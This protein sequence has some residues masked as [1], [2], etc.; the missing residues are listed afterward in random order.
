MQGVIKFVLA[1][2]L[3]GT[4]ATL[5]ALPVTAHIAA[6]RH[7][8]LYYGAA[9]GSG[10]TLVGNTGNGNG[11]IT[12]TWNF[13]IEPGDYL[14][15]VAWNHGGPQRLW[16]GNFEYQQGALATNATDWLSNIPT[17][18]DPKFNSG[19]LPVLE[20]I[21]ANIGDA[22]W[23]QTAEY[24]AIHPWQGTDDL[25]ESARY[26]GHATGPGGNNNHYVLFRTSAPLIALQTSVS[27]SSS[28]I[29]EP[30]VWLLLMAGFTGMGLFWRRAG[31]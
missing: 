19:H 5:Q 28:T 21:I 2:G 27:D 17:G 6:D 24:D 22:D 1:G 29:P 4:S 26:I 16:M 14:Y 11:L 30:P 3:L 9:D 12:Q 13:N 15:A 7:Y 25:A 18:N 20:Q 31:K 8:G 23:E 10:L